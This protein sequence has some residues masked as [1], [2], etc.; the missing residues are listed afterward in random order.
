MLI[1]DLR[2]MQTIY[3]TINQ[4]LPLLIDLMKIVAGDC[5]ANVRFYVL[6]HTIVGCPMADVG[7][8]SRVI[9]RVCK[10]S[11]LQTHSWEGQLPMLTL[12][13]YSQRRR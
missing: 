3:N 4:L 12:H 1:L 13:H 2:A 8:V 7:W 6:E 9:E 11:S 10:I 5:T